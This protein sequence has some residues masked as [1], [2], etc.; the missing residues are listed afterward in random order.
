M[1]TAN[2][3]RTYLRTVIGLGNNNEGTER[4][5]TIM[6]EGL[7]DLADIHELA[8]DD[9]IKTLCASVRKP[10]GTIP[11]P[12]WVAPNPN[13]NQLAAPQVPRT[14]KVIPAICK[15][16]LLMAAYG[17]SIYESIGREIT[18]AG[19][20]R[21]RL[22]Q[23]KLH[24]AM[25]DNHNDPQPLPDI[26][27]TYSTMKFLDQLPTY[28]SE[29]IGVNKVP[30]AYV[31]RDNVTP[32]DP[33]PPLI[34]NVQGVMTAK[35]WSDL[36]ESLMEELIAFLP[37]TGPG[38]LADNAQLFNLLAT[39]L[40]NTSAMASI[41]QYQRRRDG[42]AAYKDLV[43]HYMG[44]AKW[45]KTVE[46]AESVLS[47]RIWNGKNSRYPL[48]IHI[49]RHREAFN[50]LT[51]AAQQITYV[52]LNETS[53]VRYLLN[54]I[55]SSDPTICSGK[56]TIQANAAKKDNFELAADFLMTICPPPKHQGNT[57]RIAALKQQRG[58]KGKV[59]IG[60]K[61]GVKIRFY[62]KDEWSK[63]SREQQNE[64][65]DLRRLELKRKAEDEAG[66]K[67]CNASKI[68]ALE[69]R[70]E[71]QMQKIAALKSTNEKLEDRK[72]IQLPPKPSG[73][74]LKPPT[75]FTQRGS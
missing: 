73:N 66:S 3:T 60:P 74:P 11:Q 20:S 22:K 15:Q 29:V 52:P 14:G 38:Y 10:A 46:Q 44:S 54:S 69:T 32:I 28:L 34:D 39:Q 55:Q 50:D 72:E 48:R 8:D 75:G 42:R 58:R 1:V 2:A 53:R 30:L 45:E 47:S 12:G 37:H 23:F 57:H 56:T 43:T 4:A 24:K 71:E 21:A 40:G 25:V 7:N 19:L 51:R 61:T 26:S 62:R 18:P 65:R 35:S 68:A 16:R 36:H 41:T 9:G 31:I 27:K 59:K 33:L 70:L 67:D 63:L 6:I 17:A 5:K 49:S 64:V 13:P